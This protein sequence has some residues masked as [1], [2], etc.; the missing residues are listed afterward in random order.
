MEQLVARRAHNPKVARSS[1]VPATSEKVVKFWQPF[2]VYR[3]LLFMFV[4]YVGLCVGEFYSEENKTLKV[5][6][7]IP[8]VV[9][10]PEPEFA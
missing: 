3:K 9:N 8:V 4:T 1:R 6:S 5:N 7:K 2:F 10:N